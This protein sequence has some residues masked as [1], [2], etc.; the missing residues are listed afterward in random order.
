[1]SNNIRKFFELST[2]YGSVLNGRRAKAEIERLLD[3]CQLNKDEIF[4]YWDEF[5]SCFEGFDCLEEDVKAILSNFAYFYY[6]EK[7]FL[8]SRLLRLIARGAVY[9]GFS[10][11]VKA[12]WKLKRRVRFLGRVFIF[13]GRRGLSLCDYLG[14]KF[15]EKLCFTRL[16]SAPFINSLFHYFGR[17]PKE[18]IEKNI[19][20]IPVCPNTSPVFKN[21]NSYG[22]ALIGLDLLPSGGELYFIE[23]NFTP[24]HYMS[25]HN[26]FPEGDTLC[27]HLVDYAKQCGFSKVAFYPTNF[28]QHFKRD[29]EIEWEKIA[30]KNEIVID[31]IDDDYLGSPWKRKVGTMINYKEKGCLF[32]V[33]RY[34]DSPVTNLVVRKGMMEKAIDV[35]NQKCKNNKKIPLPKIIESNAE[36]LKLKNSKKYPNI[37]VKNKYVDQAKGIH[38]FNVKSLPDIS[39]DQNYIVSEFRVPDTIKKVVDGKTEE[40]VYLFRTYLLLTP[41]G[42]IYL[43]ARKDISGTPVPE[44][45]NEGEVP[46][47][48]PYIT[49]LNKPGDYCIGHSPEEDKACEKA[50]LKIGRF[51]HAYVEKKYSFSN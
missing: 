12:G 44:I 19:N 28:Q 45:L 24:G 26:C 5:L 42:P 22:C 9:K 4:N 6:K 10:R 2:S 25:R 48:T 31:I 16:Y 18:L 23:S 33:G 40:F 43:G 1:M 15:L 51:L 20:Q 37:I 50:T 27:W 30:S 13:I 21:S 38:I 35:Y 41:Q 34:V 7:A 8:S 47:I 36:L 32:V 11:L 29:L 39:M 17:D 14:E 46:N 49:N 3:D